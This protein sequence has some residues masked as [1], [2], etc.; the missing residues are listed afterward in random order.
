MSEEYGRLAG[1]LLST[2]DTSKGHPFADIA[3]EMVSRLEPK[4]RSMLRRV[5]M[6]YFGND[7]LVD[8]A[9]SEVVLERAIRVVELWREEQSKSID[10][11]FIRT[12]RR[13]AVKWAKRQNRFITGRVPRG[14]IDAET[15]GAMGQQS[16]EPSQAA[17][18]AETILSHLDEFDQ[19][20]IRNKDMEGYTF[21]EMADVMDIC[22]STVRKYYRSAMAR[23]RESIEPDEEPGRKE[24]HEPVS[25]PIEVEP[26]YALEQNTL[27]GKLVIYRLP[28]EGP[29]H[30]NWRRLKT[31]TESAVAKVLESLDSELEL[32]IIP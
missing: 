31:G 2:T 29:Q 10:G 28:G 30:G 20:L 1:R 18:E 6:R 23:L 19:W 13:Y 25:E 11:Y 4:L 8:D 7:S 14:S 9:F 3:F 17:A 27:T 24:D 22:K 21:A 5:C 26:T 15:A 16:Y 12:M 32:E